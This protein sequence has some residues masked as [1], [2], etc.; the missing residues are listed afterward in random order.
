V[1]QGDGQPITALA[2]LQSNWLAVLKAG[3]IYLV[4]TAATATGAADWKIEPLTLADGCVGPEA[5]CAVGNDVWY[6]G[7]D[8][9]RS[10]GRMAGAAGQWE[11]TEPLSRPVQ[12]YV[13]R[14]N[15]E[16]R[17]KIRGL[18]YKHLVLWAVPLDA[19]TEPDTVLVY[20]LRARGWAVWTGWTIAGWARSRFA[21]V[22][23]LEVVR[24]ASGIGR[25]MDDYDREDPDT[26]EDYEEAVTCRMRTRG[27]VFNE[28]EQEKDLLFAEVKLRNAQ[29]DV[30]VTVYVDER[31]VATRTL[32]VG[33]VP[34]TLG[35]H[36]LLPFDLPGNAGMKPYRVPLS[37]LPHGQ[38]FQLELEAA[39]GNFQLKSLAVM[40]LPGMLR[41][42]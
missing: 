11:V 6:W 42:E 33:Y 8:G 26:F 24:T 9:V 13:D 20:D 19:A 21:D 14:I 27:L 4:N 39:D 37:F 17:G 18:L 12:P 31:P 10:I 16:H 23:H 36:L 35:P 34:V 15:A 30:T 2:S 25:Y 28:P 3:S 40:A 22:P 32:A 7:Q 38:E 29:A 1:G 41:C 5:V